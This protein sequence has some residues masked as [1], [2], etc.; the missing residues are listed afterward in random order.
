MEGRVPPEVLVLAE[1]PENYG[2]LSEELAQRGFSVSMVEWGGGACIGSAEKSAASLVLVQVDDLAEVSQADIA[3]LA[4]ERPGQRR[5]VVV[6]R[7]EVEDRV[8][9]LNAG[10][11]MC[12][13]P[14][15]S[16]AELL[17]RLL[18]LLRR[19]S[20]HREHPTLW[21]GQL[22]MDLVR[23]SA[24]YRGRRLNLSSYEYKVLR[25]LVLRVMEC[26]SRFSGGLGDERLTGALRRLSEYAEGLEQRSQARMMHPQSLPSGET[27]DTLSD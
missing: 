11:D 1:R 20:F 4:G 16:R 24:A 3:Q 8:R 7:G 10:A 18:A 21:E 9:V 27:F 5:I 22:S 15:L 13:A 14:G 26:R 25:D 12:L 23:R 6:G 19:P 2:G 17:A